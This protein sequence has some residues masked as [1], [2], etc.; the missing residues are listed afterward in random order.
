MTNSVLRELTNNVKTL[1]K[2]VEAL[3]LHL[4]DVDEKLSKV[5]F[6]MVKDR[7]DKMSVDSIAALSK[8]IDGL[9]GVEVLQDVMKLV[10]LKTDI[11][12]VAT[13]VSEWFTSADM[14]SA[15]AK[16]M[17]G[18][19]KSLPPG[20]ERESL[21]RKFSE[22]QAEANK[23]HLMG[24][25]GSMTLEQILLGVAG[26]EE[27]RYPMLGKIPPPM[28]KKEKPSGPAPPS[29]MKPPIVPG[30]PKYTTDNPPPRMSKLEDQK[31]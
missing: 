27:K 4:N 9:A 3:Q 7:L 30:I 5:D 11:I 17:M 16:E 24:Q 8:K 12:F 13:L 2:K 1:T 22:Y 28:V 21:K 26:E 23:F 31:D 14:L 19:I 20:D 25:G 10:D 6:E 18:A 29:A 15:Q